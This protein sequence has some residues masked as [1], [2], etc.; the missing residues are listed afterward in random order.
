MSRFSLLILN[1]FLFVSSYGQ[2]DPSSLLWEIT[3]NGISKPSYVFGTIHLIPKEDYFFSK[4]NMEMLKNCKV[5]ALEIDIESMTLQQKVDLAKKAL[6][7][8][9][10][11]LSDLMGEEKYEKMKLFLIT[12]YGI[13]EKRIDSKYERIK[14]FF[15]SGIILKDKIGK[16]KTYEA[17]LIK[18][19]KKHKLKTM[20]LETIEEQ[21][22]IIDKVSMEEQI[23][24]YL[25]LEELDDYDTLL[26]YYKSQNLD[27]LYAAA[28]ESIEKDSEF[29]EDFIN[30]RNRKWIP[31]MVSEMIIQ[32]TF[33]AVG[34]LHL[35]GDN[36]VLQ[37]LRNKGYIV[38]P[39]K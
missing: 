14:P 22:A 24:E 29:E 9:N 26:K 36:G 3:G 27:S 23:D 4:K 32:P 25:N 19:A 37:L 11:K 34:A 1:I 10:Q 8:A 21:M 35:P 5:L 15:L 31:R 20:G 12:E 17:E 7:P 6:M 13:S 39:I 33:F 30:G 28:N 18:Y 16:V 2:G 38:N